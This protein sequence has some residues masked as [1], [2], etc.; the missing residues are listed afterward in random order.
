MYSFFAIWGNLKYILMAVLFSPYL[1]EMVNEE[2]GE[3]EK[4]MQAA[5]VLYSGI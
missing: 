4:K 3:Y 1:G 5:I 2:A